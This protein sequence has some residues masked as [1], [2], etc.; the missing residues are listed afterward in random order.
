MWGVCVSEEKGRNTLNV[1]I[2]CLIVYDF[3]SVFDGAKLL[4]KHVSG[5]ASEKVCKG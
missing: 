3:S 2:Q 1:F 5:L 4:P